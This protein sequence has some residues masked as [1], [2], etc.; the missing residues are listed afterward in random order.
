MKPN[1]SLTP[2]S[3][4]AKSFI[5]LEGGDTELTPEVIRN[6]VLAL[7]SAMK[8]LPDV[9]KCGL[10]TMHNFIDGVYT[11]TVY[12]PAGT[13]WTGQ[14]HSKEHIVIVSKGSANVVSEDHGATFLQAPAIFNSPAGVK[15][16]LFIQTDMIFT[17]VHPNPTN[18]RDLKQLEH[19]LTLGAD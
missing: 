11:R 19:A 18:T 4:D 17:T 12:M 13:L 2:Q 9:A 5:T 6:S 16:L 8:G 3:A 7:E 1:L 10:E 15:R 14:I